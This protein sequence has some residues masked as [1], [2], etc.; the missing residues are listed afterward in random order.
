MPDYVRR[1]GLEHISW[2]KCKAG[3]S[4]AGQVAADLET[5]CTHLHTGVTWR[6]LHSIATAPVAQGGLNLMGHLSPRA[7]FIFGKAPPTLLD[8]RPELMFEFCVWLHCGRTRA[9]MFYTNVAS[10]I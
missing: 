2:T 5:I 7:H 4:E 9:L 3:L 1:R 8:G 6:R 10:W